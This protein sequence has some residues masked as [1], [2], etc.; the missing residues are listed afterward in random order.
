MGILVKNKFIWFF[1]KLF[2]VIWPSRCHGAYNVAHIYKIV[3][4]PTCTQAET[5]VLRNKL[6]EYYQVNSKSRQMHWSVVLGWTDSIKKL[7]CGWVVSASIGLPIQYSP[8]DWQLLDL[9]HGSPGFKS[10]TM[11]INSQLFCL[12]PVGI[13]NN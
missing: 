5:S 13:L 12:Q 10:S 1:T 8:S 9:F 3:V 2:A 7:V 4:S 6:Q 11:I